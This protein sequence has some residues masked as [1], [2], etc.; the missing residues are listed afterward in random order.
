MSIR[1]SLSKTTALVLSVIAL[2]SCSQKKTAY[3]DVFKLV[4]EFELQKEYTEEAKREMNRSKSMT[5][6]VLYAEKIR[7]PQ[8]VEQLRNQLYTELY[9]KTDERT[10]QIE[11]MI[12][13]RLNPYLIDYGKEHGYQYIYGANGTGNVLYAD[14]DLDITDDVIKYANDRYHD[15]K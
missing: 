7:N 3:V 12:W 2:S 10:K 8:G 5:D 13:K 11:A 9:R 15:K 6:S 14:K 1:S 4:N